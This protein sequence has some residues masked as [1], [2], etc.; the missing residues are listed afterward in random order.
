MGKRSGTYTV[1]AILQALIKDRSCSQRD[2]ARRTGVGVDTVRKHLEELLAG[3]FP[4]ERYDDPPQVWW[5][6][7]KGWFPGAVLFEAEN[8]PV[9][10]RQLSRLP[11]S[12][13]RE[14]LIRTILDAAPRPSPPAPTVLTAQW[15]E[16]EE[17]HLSLIEDAEA[18]QAT[19]EIKYR[20]TSHHEAQWRSVSVQRVV[21]GPPARFIA[22]CHKAEA[23]RWFR[24]DNVARVIDDTARPFQKIEVALVA[25]ML[26]QSVD[27]FH[28]GD[29]L[30]CSFFVRD[31]DARWVESNLPVSITP[32]RVT[33]GTRFTT[34]TAGVL[35]L[36]R[37]VV[38]LGV[39][40]RAET[41]ELAAQVKELARGALEA[42]SAREEA[43][44]C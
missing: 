15:T 1:V 22:Y 29:A 26:K 17:K 38:G 6:V 39:A 41:P 19:I 11:R 9:L 3:G 7:P 21:F 35:R 5:S 33:G 25:A 40:A 18:K 23:L 20:S 36:A 43:A 44:P 32:E 30:Q 10:L 34:T 37:Y 24:V 27:G 31:P 42:S 16:P 12:K 13:I 14:Q 4:L 2:L 8:V 28:R